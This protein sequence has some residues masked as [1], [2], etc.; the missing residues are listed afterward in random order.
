LSKLNTKEHRILPWFPFGT[1]AANMIAC[2]IDFIIGGLTNR[3]SLGYWPM[4]ILPAIRVGYAGS[5]STVSTFIAEVGN[6]I[7][8]C[9]RVPLSIQLA[10]QLTPSFQHE[11]ISCTICLAHCSYTTCFYDH[12]HILAPHNEGLVSAVYPEELLSCCR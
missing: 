6:K 12:G 10:L 5:L 8:Q 7:W 3:Y 4:V 1:F 11:R 2:C 9:S